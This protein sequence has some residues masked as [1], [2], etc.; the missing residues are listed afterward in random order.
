MPPPTTISNPTVMPPDAAAQDAVRELANSTRDA[1]DLPRLCD[2]LRDTIGTKN[3]YLTK[4]EIDSAIGNPKITGEEAQALVA[5]KRHFVDIAKLTDDGKDTANRISKAD[6]AAATKMK[7]VSDAMEETRKTVEKAKRTLFADNC[8]PL[9]SVSSE[10]VV[11]A[12]IGNCYYFAALAS[13]A[14]C[15]PR[16]IV[17]MIADHKDGTYTVTF[18]GGKGIKVNAPTDAELVLFP[19]PTDKGTWVHVM[20]KAYGQHCMDDSLYRA[21]R[22]LRGFEDSVVP[23]EHAD[24]GSALDAGLRVLT[25]K[26]IG[27][28]WSFNGPVAMHDALV[29]ATTRGVPITADTG[30]QAKVEN[31][32]ATQHVYSVLKYDDK[33]KVMTVRNPWADGVPKVKGVVDKGKGVFEIPLDTF[34]AYFTKISYPKK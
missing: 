22:K 21:L 5:L 31:G 30:L 25:N 14:D 6:V 8:K 12:G 27:W 15:S 13:L 26:S 10:S 11:Q 18:P 4:A 3:D 32:P 24:G 19:K 28:T 9:E 2:K 34:V 23:Q 20:E 17:D 1:N 33:A 29:D 16:S 7:E